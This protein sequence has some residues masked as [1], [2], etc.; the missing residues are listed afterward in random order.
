MDSGDFPLKQGN[1][2]G[3]AADFPPGFPP[4]ADTCSRVYEAAADLERWKDVPFQHLLAFA[5][6]A[7]SVAA[8]GAAA[9]QF[10]HGAD[11]CGVTVT[12]PEYEFGL[13]KELTGESSCLFTPETPQKAREGTVEGGNEQAGVCDNADGNNA[14]PVPDTSSTVA[15]AQENQDSQ[16]RRKPKRKKHVPKVMV[17]GRKPK[18]R[19]PAA[20]KPKKSTNNEQPKGS[21]PNAANSGADQTGERKNNNVNPTEVPDPVACKEGVPRSK[22]KYTKKNN[23]AKNVSASNP[24]TTSE[25]GSNPQAPEVAVK[26]GTPRVKRKY[27]KKAETRDASAS[28]P[29]ENAEEISNSQ[30]PKPAEAAVPNAE[31]EAAFAGDMPCKRRNMGEDPLHKCPTTPPTEATG[32][33]ADSQGPPQPAK[34]SCR[35]TLDF[36]SQ[37]PGGQNC[38]QSAS[39]SLGGEVEVR[40]QKSSAGVPYDFNDYVDKV[41]R[42]YSTKMGFIEPTT[43]IPPNAECSKLNGN[44]HEQ[45]RGKEKVGTRLMQ[46]NDIA[47]SQSAAASFP[48]VPD[49]S[50]SCGGGRTLTEVG[51]ASGS[52]PN[53]CINMTE[54]FYSSFSLHQTFPWEVLM[55]DCRETGSA[56]CQNS[57]LASEM[58]VPTTAAPNINPET[59]GEAQPNG[60]P[61]G[62]STERRFKAPS[63]YRDVVS[64]TTNLPRTAHAQPSQH[65]FNLNEPA[66]DQ[67]S[68]TTMKRSKKDPNE[69][70]KGF[71][72]VITSVNRDQFAYPTSAGAG[73]Y[74]RIVDQMFN[75]EALTQQLKRLNLNRKRRGNIA[76]I[77]NNELVPYSPPG[78]Q[79]QNAMVLYRGD[80]NSMMVP[81][82]GPMKRRRPRAKVDLDQETVRVFNLLL[83]NIDSEGVDGTDEQ[84]ARYWEE[85][86]SIF[87]GR[88][89]S[90]IARMHLVQGDRRFS[91]WKGSVVDSVIGVFLTQNVSDHLSS[92]AFMSMA[93]RFPAKRHQKPCWEEGTRSIVINPTVSMPDEE[94]SNWDH[95]SIHDHQHEETEVPHTIGS[96]RG[97]VESGPGQEKYYESVISSQNSFV[98][99]QNSNS[100]VSQ[101]VDRKE[102]SSETN[103]QEMDA[104]DGSQQ[105]SFV[106]LLE[107]PQFGTSTMLHQSPN[108]S[109]NTSSVSVK[110]LRHKEEEVKNLSDIVESNKERTSQKTA[111]GS[112]SERAKG[113]KDVNA[114]KRKAKSRRVGD[115]IRDDADWEALRKTAEPNGSKE[116]T[117]NSMDS[118]DWEAV[119]S[120]DVSEIAETIKARGMNR[121]LAGRIKEF[122]DKV[123]SYH[124][125]VDLEWLRDVHPD[126]AKEYLLSFNGLGLKSVECVRLLTLHHLAFP[127]DTNVGR[128]AVRLGWVPLQPLP[129]SLQLHLLEM[130]PI[131]DTIQ[132]YL[133]PRLCKLDQKTLYELHYQLITFGKVFC[134]KSKPNCNACPMRGECRHFASA[135]ASARLSLPGPE[136]KRMV[137]VSQDRPTPSAPVMP[138][139]QRCLPQLTICEQQIH[140][141]ESTPAPN[142]AE[143]ENLHLSSAK[144]RENCEPIIEEPLSPPQ[145][146]VADIGDIEDLFSQSAPHDIEDTFY[147]DPDEIPTIKL[148]EIPAITLNVQELAQNIEKYIKQNMDLREGGD[149]SLDLVAMATEATYIPPPKLKNISRLRTEHRVYELSD[150]HPLVEGLDKREEDDPSPYLF[151]IWTPGETADSIKPPERTCSSQSQDTLCEEGTCSSCS[152]YSEARRQVVRGTIL[153]PCRTAMRG[154]FP[155]NGTYFQVNEVFADHETSMKPIEVPRSLLWNL[156][157]R[158]VNFGTSVPTIFRGLTTDEIQQCFWRGFVCVRGFDR[159]TRAPRPLMARLHFPAS[160]L[161]PSKE[162]K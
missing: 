40:V 127:V 12:A 122:L 111:A 158:T 1:W 52:L 29:A 39:I 104:W 92:S 11:P 136:E 138:D 125:S 154:S 45:D 134:T 63:R 17:D 54:P 30:A 131:L 137:N 74:D 33:S 38:S 103:S 147:E 89:D 118:V 65:I 47:I 51:E 18:P 150:S 14:V 93:A 42:S 27:T 4:A 107:M 72:G 153:I 90:F 105:S 120:A 86:R 96:T 91:K 2:F 43:A 108:E 143:R 128:I 44:S 97:N 110:E 116:R 124:G 109:D 13:P 49:A 35:R 26:D 32:E 66:G 48:S 79:K 80:N 24:T 69:K 95:I 85:Q 157:R 101:T 22:R 88:T 141:S 140:S 145:Q 15:M 56:N 57:A 148:N 8:T 156:P 159:A 68:L 82:D 142:T 67:A 146:A 70:G 10:N 149:M 62:M 53:D 58:A 106:E 115:E 100:P 36:G 139:A 129:E 46:Q 61:S 162:K 102:P 34:R 6:C 7:P 55:Q 76:R 20:E 41:L 77:L 64:N 31:A 21:G 28:K 135:F 161:K 132:K 119:R 133:W 117:E 60:S 37:E 113:V 151:A 16:I 114:A 23:A 75:V 112:N 130:Y 59:H 121:V 9:T 152:S 73:S 78:K 160:K 123:V 50:Q 81:Y 94:T 144:S 84:N 5:D 3:S 99:S 83:K 87:R 19:K 98:S 155:L 71:D 126:R 25:E